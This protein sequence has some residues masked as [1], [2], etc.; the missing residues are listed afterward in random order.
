MPAPSVIAG[1]NLANK[2]GCSQGA[3]SP[4]RWELCCTRQPCRLQSRDKA[5]ETPAS[6]VLA[7]ITDPGY[8]V[9][10]TAESGRGRGAG[11]GLGVGVGLGA[12]VG[13]GVA[14]GV[15]VGVGVGVGVGVAGTIAYA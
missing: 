11:R 1:N 5:G 12:N 9:F 10:T 3:A 4:C 13:V 14:L 7:G 2:A 15:T 6:T 8:N